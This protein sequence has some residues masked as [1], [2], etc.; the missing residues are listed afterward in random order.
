MDS[1]TVTGSKAGI[2]AVVMA[3]ALMAMI[4]ITIVNVALSDIRAS[5]GTPIDQIGWVSTGYMM[6]NIVIIPMTGWF[7]R[8]FGYR[9]YFAGSVLLFTAAS[10]LCALAWDL[11]SLVLFRAIQ[12][13]GGGAIIPT[14]QSILFARYPRKEHGMAAALYG[15]GAITGPL[16]G[17]TLGGYLIEWSSWH[18]IFMVN[19]PVGVLVALLT[20]RFVEQPAFEPPRGDAAK[21][22]VFGI[23]LLA[24]G[25]ASLQYVLEE[26]NREGWLESHVVVL[27]SAV[28]AIALVTFVVHELETERPVVDLRVFGNRSYAAGTGLN[29]LTGFALFSGS[30]MF[31]LFAGSVIRYSALDIGKVFL[32]AGTVSLIVMPMMGRLAPKVDGRALLLIGVGSVSASQVVASHLTAQAG[33]WDLVLPNMIRSFGL[34]FIFIPVSMLALSDLPASQRG[35][36]T[37]LFNLTRELGGSLGTALMG[38]Q[39]SDDIKRFGSYLSEHVTAYDPLVMEQLKNGAATLG[40]LTYQR[41]LVGESV[42]KLKVTTEAMVLSFENGFRYTALA[43]A[44]GFALVLLLKKPAAVADVGGAH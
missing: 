8:R 16:L 5:F 4:D 25:M 40:A 36:A 19:V 42:L 7:Q 23:V 41:E 44:L 15:L 26:G 24:A 43:M 28:A 18:W 22:D 37:G 3:A 21:V 12:G 11:P 39:V 1:E 13:L 32:V 9:K 20:L 29:F 38:M 30:Y 33:F 31:S 14:A 6:A 17:P 2:T 10:A 35:N 34:G 27:L